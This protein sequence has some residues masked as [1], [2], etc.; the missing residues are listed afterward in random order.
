MPI[1]FLKNASEIADVSWETP[2][3]V[4]ETS[5]ERKLVQTDPLLT[6]VITADTNANR[7]ILNNT[8]PEQPTLSNCSQYHT[9][10]WT[11][12]KSAATDINYIIEARST[13]F[14]GNPFLSGWFQVATGTITG[15]ANSWFRVAITAPEGLYFDQYRIRVQVASGTNT[16]TCKVVGVRR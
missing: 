8:A 7:D 3:P 12:T 4:L 9:L 1:R 6:S 11:G 14:D 13:D 5:K 15:A 16:I 2:L 10:L